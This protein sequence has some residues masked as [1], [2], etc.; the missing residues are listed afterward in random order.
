MLA[1]SQALFLATRLIHSTIVV[2]AC[3]ML[4]CFGLGQPMLT[5]TGCRE[6]VMASQVEAVARIMYKQIES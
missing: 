1:L 5:A 4:L 2:C 3:S 6:C